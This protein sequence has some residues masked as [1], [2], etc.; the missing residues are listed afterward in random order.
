MQGSLEVPCKL[1]FTGDDK[2][3][4]KVDKFIITSLAIKEKA[5]MKTKETHKLLLL[6]VGTVMYANHIKGKL[7]L[8]SGHL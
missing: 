7:K 4:E 5:I 1:K 6:G 8:V 3:I 2:Q